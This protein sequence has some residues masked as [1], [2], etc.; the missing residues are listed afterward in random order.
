MFWTPIRYNNAVNLSTIDL[1]LDPRTRQDWA[2]VSHAHSDHIAA[3]KEAIL[4]EAT[5]RFMCLRKVTPRAVTVLP[6]GEPRELRG[7]EFTLWPSGHMLGGAQVTI[8]IN[9][10][11]ILY[12]GDFK[13]KP[14]PA[15]DPIVVP[16][17]E[18]LIMETT[19]GHHRY[20]FPPEE[21]VIARMADWCTACLRDEVTPVL[22]GY[23]VGKGQEIL[24]SL[25]DRDFRFLLQDSIYHA[26]RLAESLGAIFPPYERWVPGAE[27][28]CVIICPPHLRRWAVDRLPG[29]CRTAIV[30]GWAF[31]PSTRYR[32]GANAAFC[33]SDHADY[34][35]LL[36]Y[37][38][39]VQPQQVYT[40]HGYASDFA[41]ELRRRGYDAMAL[42]QADQLAL[43]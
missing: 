28:G 4:T 38:E 26:T 21:E 41:N 12:S 40:V 23:S 37:V 20:A 1:W 8:A 39:Q 32:Y 9:N 27:A 34:Q 18:V 5:Y 22:L 17:A 36:A 14:N 43:F 35:D 2:F 25:A 16:Q 42:D 3:H 29:G 15:A 30:S 6:Y 7:V 31:D 10:R 24:A 33:L 11:R 19:F 13:L